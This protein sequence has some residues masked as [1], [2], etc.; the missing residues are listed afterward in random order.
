MKRGWLKYALHG[1]VLLG[2]GFA[3]LKYVS[4]AEVV[5]ALKQFNWLYA[6]PI[7][8]LSTAYLLSKAWRFYL[9]LAPLTPLD[10]SVTA[11]AYIAGQT[12]TLL[13]GGIAARAGLLKQAGIPVGTSS[14]PIALSSLLD[15]AV[16]LSCTLLA[17]LWFDQAR[18]PLVFFIGAL[19]VI[20]VLLGIQAIRQW[21]LGVIE[22]L[23]GRMKLLEQWREFTVSIK[24]L[25]QPRLLLYG[26]LLTLLAFVLN[27]EAL[28]LALN[29]V[30]ADAHYATLFLAFVLPTM[31]GR[32]SALPG[33]VGVTEAGMVSILSAAPDVAFAQAV[34]AVAIFRLGTV[35]F[36]AL[37]GALV[38]FFGWRGSKE[39]AAT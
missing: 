17:A 12:M 39:T 9:L 29:G 10:W 38:Y 11:R 20:S 3:A 23:L 15:Q 7:L 35:L 30:G 26:V 6:L 18:K 2:I 1:A 22:W 36:T 19:V 32:I 34:A 28:D 4:G 21:L 31:L 37:L 24:D 8:A 25:L 14:A 27:V 33:G 5:T 13:P 16:F